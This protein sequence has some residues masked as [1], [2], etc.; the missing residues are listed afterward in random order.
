M[1]PYCSNIIATSGGGRGI[2][3]PSCPKLRERVKKGSP[4]QRAKPV[5]RRGQ[6]GDV[7]HQ[8]A[9]M[10]SPEPQP[11]GGGP[12]PPEASRMGLLAAPRAAHLGQRE[13]FISLTSTVT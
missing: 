4:P 9:P 12:L 11:L 6:V 5:P 13:V 3:V 8:W 1:S 10:G 7:N 2:N